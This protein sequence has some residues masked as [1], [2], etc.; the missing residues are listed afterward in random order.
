MAN[1]ALK[2]SMLLAFAQ[3]L[4][5]ATPS[6]IVR[7]HPTEKKPN[8]VPVEE[9][10]IYRT[11]GPYTSVSEIG[12]ISYHSA[13]PDLEWIYKQLR[14]DAANQGAIAVIDLKITSE[15]HREWQTEN[16]CS[17]DT[18]CDSNGQCTTHHN[19]HDESVM[20][21]VTTYGATGTLL[22]KGSI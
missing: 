9:V 6:S 16:K 17:D 2:L 7:F 4:G 12:M 21:D 5:C 1:F 14:E 19:C 11:R 22:A 15:T 18:K 3:L 20:K 10:G 13:T 8:A